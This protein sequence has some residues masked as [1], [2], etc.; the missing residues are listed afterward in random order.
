MALAQAVRA[1]AQAGRGARREV[2]QKYVR[3]GEEVRKGCFCIIL[4]KVEYQRLLAPVGPDEIRRFTIDS[5]V[6]AAGKIAFGPF[7]LNDARTGIGQAA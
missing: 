6:V 4:P 5:V 3:F 7:D 2:L 1:E